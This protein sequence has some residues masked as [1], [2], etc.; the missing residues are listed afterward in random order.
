MLWNF[1]RD[2]IT[3]SFINKF[4]T[5]KYQCYLEYC[6]GWQSK[7]LPMWFNFGHHVHYI[8]ENV[9]TDF[10]APT[11]GDIHDLLRRYQ[12]IN[13]P[14][15]D[16]EQLR[17][18][19]LIF[20]SVSRLIQTY[21]FHYNKEFKNNWL[22]TEK[23]FKIPFEDTYLTGRF[24]GIFEDESGE[25]WLIDHKCLSIVDEDSLIAS[26]PFDLQVNLYLY[27]A[28]ESFGRFPSGL[29]YNIIRRP[30]DRMKDN[31]SPTKFAD[32]IMLKVLGK[33]DYYFIRIPLRRDPLELKDWIQNQLRPIISEIREWYNNG[34]FPRYVTPQALV[35]KYGRCSTFGLITSG[36][37][38]GL[39]KREVTF[40]ELV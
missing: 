38:Y 26:L 23:V 1:Y 6:E 31:E 40:P 7:K 9:Y 3:Q 24:D 20:E 28:T 14:D 29:I 12:G 15:P 33:L 30:G 32:R 5:C 36:S 35:G 37:T 8:L 18:N 22:H 25:L 13:F 10:K 2:G 34:C 11:V 27:A 4:L 39:R 16:N 21:F 17:E 19:Q